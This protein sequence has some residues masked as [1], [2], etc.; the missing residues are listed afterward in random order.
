MFSGVGSDLT[1]FTFP[2]TVNEPISVLQK[3]CEQMYY[4]TLLDQ[5]DE[6]S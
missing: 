1:R 5:A 4:S 2:V 6:A 3:G